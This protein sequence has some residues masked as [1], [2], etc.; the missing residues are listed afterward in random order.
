MAN[1]LVLGGSGFVGTELISQLKK[2]NDKICVMYHHHKCGGDLENVKADLRDE[3][4]IRKALNGRRFDV[5][6]HVASLPGD[7]GNPHEMIDVNVTGLLNMLEWA[8]ANPVLSYV[9]SSSISAY[10]WYPA[11]KFNPPDY[12]PVDENHPCRPKDM[13]ATSKRM[14]EL[15]ALTYYHQYKVPISALRL[16]AVVGPGGKGGGRGWRQFAEMLDEGRKVQIPHFSEDELCHYVDVRDVARMHIAAGEHPSAAGQVFNCCSKE[17]TRG[18]EFVSIVKKMV[19]DIEVEC[20]F[21]WSM[22]QGGEVS[23][24][25]EKA[26]NLLGFEPL[27]SLEDSIRS[28]KQWIDAGGLETNKGG[29]RDKKFSTGIKED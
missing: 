10:E 17:P 25:M 29:D 16:T 11:T 26:K 18:S 21:A 24:S 8:R 1:V 22:A 12:M 20:G 9:L 14:Q 2:R 28:I 4:S 27:Y 5:I 15:L 3:N 19:P 7:T 13:Y 23:F 6:Y